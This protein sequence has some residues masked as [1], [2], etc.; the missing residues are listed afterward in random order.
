MQSTLFHWNICQWLW[1]RF[2]I[3]TT[4]MA[5]SLL[6]FTVEQS[7]KQLPHEILYTH[8]FSA[9][10]C[11]K[12][13]FFVLQ[14][15]QK[16]IGN[17]PV[18]QAPDKFFSVSPMVG[19]PAKCD[20]KRP[21]LQQNRC[22]LVVSAYQVEI[23]GSNQVKDFSE[24]LQYFICQ[25]W[26]TEYISDDVSFILNLRLHLLSQ[27]ICGKNSYFHHIF[28]ERSKKGHQHKYAQAQQLL[29]GPGSHRG[30]E[31]CRLWACF[32]RARNVTLVSFITSQVR[33]LLGWWIL[34]EVMK[35]IRHS[36]FQ[37]FNS[38]LN[39]K[40]LLSKSYFCPVTLLP[41]LEL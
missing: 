16:Q 41:A 11:N 24:R 23:W 10:P 31:K 22:N 17:L 37:T 34:W 19:F 20:S 5:W 8:V 29:G 15:T 35:V 27:M 26:L 40:L 14:N 21:L 2:F 12:I 7:Q 18:K 6:L 30:Y 13:T 4:V 28:C 3:V 36:L 33:K 1:Q 25:H 9:A 38:H 32:T 39:K